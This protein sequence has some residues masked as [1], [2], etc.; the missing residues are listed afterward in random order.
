MYRIMDTSSQILTNRKNDEYILL[1]PDDVL[2]GRQKKFLKACQIIIEQLK[3]FV[4]KS[5]PFKSITYHVL[6][7]CV[8]Q[9]VPCVPR[10]DPVFQE[11]CFPPLPCPQGHPKSAKGVDTLSFKNHTDSLIP[12]TLRL[13]SML[14]FAPQE[15]LSAGVVAFMLK[16]A[17]SLHEPHL[18]WD[19][20][21]LRCCCH[22]NLNSFCSI[23]WRRGQ[24]SS[25]AGQLQSNLVGRC[26]IHLLLRI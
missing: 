5:Q 6:S 4:V 24:S 8:Y 2:V 3:R 14:M 19:H 10:P 17:P 12:H 23:S 16:T 15:H 13:T 7:P 22:L 21:H 25:Q 9:I 26:L 1:D 11:V 18:S 20:K